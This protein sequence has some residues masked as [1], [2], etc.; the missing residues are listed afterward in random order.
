MSAE[1][2]HKISTDSSVDEA[3]VKAAAE[4][5]ESIDDDDA[6][7]AAKQAEFEDRIK[8]LLVKAASEASDVIKEKE[9]DLEKSRGTYGSDRNT[10]SADRDPKSG[11]ESTPN[12]NPGYATNDTNSGPSPKAGTEAN[13]ANGATSE[14]IPMDR[15]DE[16]DANDNKGES[17]VKE[18][19]QKAVGLGRQD[20]K[21]DNN[22]AFRRQLT[23]FYIFGEYGQNLADW[24]EQDKGRVPDP[25]DADSFIAYLRAVTDFL[26]RNGAFTYVSGINKDNRLT[27]GQEVWFDVEDSLTDATGVQVVVIKTLDSQDKEQVIGTIRTQYEFEAYDAAVEDGKQEKSKAIEA[28]RKLYEEVIRR[29]ENGI[30][31]KV[32]TKVDKLAKGSLPLVQINS[33][34][35]EVFEVGDSTEDSSVPIIGVAAPRTANSPTIMIH[36]GNRAD[37]V[38]EVDAAV[39]L[40]G[41]VYVLIP[42]NT[43]QYVPA[44]CVS[45]PM[46]ELSKDDWY[47]QQAVNALWD[48]L[49]NGISRKNEFIKW[50]PVR[51]LHINL[52]KK[53]EQGKWED[54]ILGQADAV[55]IKFT[56]KDG[57]EV[58]ITVSLK[59]ASGNP[60]SKETI[61]A[62]LNKF[63]MDTGKYQGLYTNVDKRKLSDLNYVRNMSRYLRV[64]LPRGLGGQHTMNDGFLYI[65]TS[66]EK[67]HT[68]GTTVPKTPVETHTTPQGTSKSVIYKGKRYTVDMAGQVFDSKNVP[69]RGKLAE[70]IKKAINGATK[71]STAGV[72]KPSAKRP[73]KDP[74]NTRGGRRKPSTPAKTETENLKAVFERVK[75]Q[76]GSST[77][78][79]IALGFLDK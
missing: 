72:K 17:K 76:T 45:T 42:S 37:N 26:S 7:R 2:L 66:I 62:D 35:A 5:V 8:N 38:A 60:L 33:T 15:E 46:A 73:I 65:P 68:D 40:P 54:A 3:I 29:H 24:Y 74:F 52:R 14:E 79:L 9:K 70:E 75:A 53:K 34:V 18:T 31:D 22:L 51:D 12:P 4:L 69:I 25:L 59:D 44:L 67:Q 63:I 43:G 71:A 50:L 21:K 56:G 55:F 27:S 6:V 61:T 78:V 36:N 16:Y 13:P 47:I 20:T 77:R 41:Q 28:Q 10:S 1:G 57:R 23:E 58:N 32:T 49:E 39:L 30:T 64:N 48:V 11:N 19:R